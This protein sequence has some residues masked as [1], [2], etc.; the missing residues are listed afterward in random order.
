MAEAQGVEAVARELRIDHRS[1]RPVYLQLMDGIKGLAYKSRISA[2]FQLP[3]VR[4]LASALD[5]NPNTVAR[6][7]RELEHEGIVYSRVGRGT[8]ISRFDA[9]DEKKVVES[10]MRDIERELQS[11]CA[12][13]GLSEE[14]F[15]DYIRKKSGGSR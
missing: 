8:F 15:L 4:A 2:G 13:L 10:R 11:R 14:Q 6:A 9:E 5:I 1:E 12:Q 3:T 7:Y